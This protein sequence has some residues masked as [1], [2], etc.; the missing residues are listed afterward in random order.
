MGCTVAGCA[1]CGISIN[2]TFT[3]ASYCD[4]SAECMK[5]KESYIPEGT[6]YAKM[7]VALL[8]DTRVA[9]GSEKPETGDMPVLAD[10]FEVSLMTVTDEL[11]TL[12]SPIT[13]NLFPPGCEGKHRML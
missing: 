8:G 6:M 3:S 11:I 5:T 1:Y 13:N 10:V 2:G 12:T 4:G 9:T 7:D